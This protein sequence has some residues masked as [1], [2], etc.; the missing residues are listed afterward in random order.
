MIVVDLL[1]RLGTK[2]AH[3]RRVHRLELQE[4][5]PVMP[6]A[7]AGTTAVVISEGAASVG[8]EFLDREYAS[9]EATFQ[10]ALVYCP[11]TASVWY[12]H[13]RSGNPVTDGRGGHAVRLGYRD[14]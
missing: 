14:V 9:T 4:R 1:C 3:A 13:S 11:V 2:M 12:L 5:K 8:V 7:M 10:K 6:R